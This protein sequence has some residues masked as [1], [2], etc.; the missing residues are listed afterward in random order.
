MQ[1]LRAPGRRA[2][3]STTLRKL[4][5]PSVDGAACA[6]RSTYSPTRN[7]RRSPCTPYGSE[8][9]CFGALTSID[10]CPW[11][12]HALFSPASARRVLTSTDR[13][14]TSCAQSMPNLASSTSRSRGRSAADSQGFTGGRASAT[15]VVSVCTLSLLSVAVGASASVKPVGEWPI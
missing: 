15:I 3:S 6:A 7:M 11:P 12:A 2:G 5:E 9:P 8:I 1:V 14:G 4:L 10:W 13:S